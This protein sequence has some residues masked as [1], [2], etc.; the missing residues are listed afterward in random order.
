MD[1]ECLLALSRQ[2]EPAI[3]PRR[4]VHLSGGTDSAPPF[5]PA[6]APKPDRHHHAARAEDGRL[7]YDSQ[8]YG[9]GQAICINKKDEHPSRWVPQRSVAARGRSSDGAALF[10]SPRESPPPVGTWV[11]IA[12]SGVGSTRSVARSLAGGGREKKSGKNNKNKLFIVPVKQGLRLF[13]RR[14]HQRQ[15]RRAVVQTAGR[16]QV[17]TPPLS[18]AEGQI[19]HQALVEL[20]AR[21]AAE[22]A[23]AP[24]SA[25][26]LCKYVDL[27]RRGWHTV[28][29]SPDRRSKTSGTAGA[30]KEGTPPPPPSPFPAWRRGRRGGG[31]A[32]ATRH[33]GRKSVSGR[34]G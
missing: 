26:R 5:S 22:G 19:H 29:S 1:G 34:W 31:G 14:H 32:G 13:Q 21:P 23:A 17:Q 8:W 11:T 10:Y 18:A 6:A 33:G 20:H 3:D 2:Y 7:F 9:R 15:Q 4:R 30:R 12:A 28:A 27:Y 25:R 16:L 24:H